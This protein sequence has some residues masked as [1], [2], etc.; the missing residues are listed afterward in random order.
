M[1]YKDQISHLCS[2]FIKGGSFA[3]HLRR[4]HEKEVSDDDDVGQT[5]STSVRS[6]AKST[7]FRRMPVKSGASTSSPVSP[8][9]IHN[10]VLCMLRSTE[11]VN[12]PAMSD[13]LSAYFPDIPQT[14]Q[15]AIIVSAFAAAQKAA[16]T[17]S[18]IVLNADEDRVVSAKRSIEVPVKPIQQRTT[19]SRLVRGISCA[20]SVLTDDQF[21]ARTPISCSVSVA[22]PS[23]TGF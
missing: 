11:K 12:L 2:A 10:A 9:Y 4:C 1:P 19:V 3:H 7:R 17:Y 5:D 22:F 23:G 8:D 15:T 16:A 6:D 21:R 14:W 20:R 18:D 13:Y